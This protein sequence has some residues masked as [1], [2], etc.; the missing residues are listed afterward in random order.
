MSKQCLRCGS[1][2][3][4]SGVPLVDRYGEYGTLGGN[5]QMYVHGKPEAWVFKDTA[6]GSVIAD[7]CGDCGYAE[8]TVTDFRELY[9][10]YLKSGKG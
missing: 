1:S 10:K 5:A 6:A 8:L 4:M 3:I 9:E 7:I 2:K